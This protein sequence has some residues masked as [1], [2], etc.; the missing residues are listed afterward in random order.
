[1]SLSDIIQCILLACIVIILMANWWEL[2]WIRFDR[3]QKIIQNGEK[4]RFI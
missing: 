1:M 3:E 2:R 4:D